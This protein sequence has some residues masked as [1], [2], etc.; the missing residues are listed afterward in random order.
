MCMANNIKNY[1]ERLK[2]LIEDMQKKIQDPENRKDIIFVNNRL[3][4]LEYTKEDNTTIIN[5]SKFQTDAM[6]NQSVWSRYFNG[7]NIR[8]SHDTFLKIVIGLHLDQE[9]AEKYLSMVGDGFRLTDKRDQ[10]I[11]AV[12]KL[13]YFGETEIEKVIEMIQK[14]LDFFSKE[15][16][17]HGGKPF[18]TLYEI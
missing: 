2:L 9:A 13:D 6:L 4:E 7:T 8:T 10:I 16:V 3:I 11:L 12:I 18:S 5:Y 15:E 14:Y 17:K 1:N